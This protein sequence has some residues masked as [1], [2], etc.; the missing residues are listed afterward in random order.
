MEL[1]LLLESVPPG[2][3]IWPG[4]QNASRP[5]PEQYEQW[6]SSVQLYA[7]AES[8]CAPR[9]TSHN[10]EPTRSVR[11]ATAHGAGPRAAVSVIPHRAGAILVMMRFLTMG[12][13][14]GVTF[15]GTASVLAISKASFAG[16][17][18]ESPLSASFCKV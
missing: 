5:P 6:L 7:S 16:I 13:G 11:A 4:P 10:N 3:D 17:T 18:E 14:I 9:S 2:G 1:L 15:C 12:P 8:S